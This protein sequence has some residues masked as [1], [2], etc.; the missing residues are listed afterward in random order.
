MRL[1]S[2]GFTLAQ[3]LVMLA[4]GGLTGEDH[5][6]CRGAQGPDREPPAAR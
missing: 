4:L 6:T 2:K 1:D 3:L 5:R